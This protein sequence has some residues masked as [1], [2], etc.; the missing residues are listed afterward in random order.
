M[1]TP[2]PVTTDP[3]PTTTNPTPRPPRFCHLRIGAGHLTLCCK[4][5]AT[6]GR[7]YVGAAWCAPG[8][9]FCRAKG[10]LIAEGRASCRRGGTRYALPALHGRS[11]RRVA[12]GVIAA[13]P[14]AL[15]GWVALCEAAE[16]SLYAFSEDDGRRYGPCAEKRNATEAAQ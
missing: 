2:Q 5:D 1:T 4:R 13:Y 8:D 15:P 7:H 14:D 11:W 9:Q 3:Q 12:A 16:E 10:R 6:D